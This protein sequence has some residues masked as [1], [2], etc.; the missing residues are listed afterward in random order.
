MQYTPPSVIINHPTH[1][2]SLTHTF[3]ST[4]YFLVMVHVFVMGLNISMRSNTI[5]Y[6]CVMY[7]LL[8]KWCHSK[9]TWSVNSK[10]HNKHLLWQCPGYLEWWLD[11][12]LHLSVVYLV[13]A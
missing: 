1:P 9:G 6:A 3:I 10:A 8:M 12:N 4:Y 13:F 7:M 5:I 2:S 11:S